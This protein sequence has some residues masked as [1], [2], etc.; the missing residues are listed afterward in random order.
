MPTQRVE[1]DA[2]GFH[3]VILPERGGSL[4]RVGWRHPDGE[5]RELFERA[6]EAAIEDLSGSLSKL[7][8]FVMIP[9][10]N[11]IDGARFMYDG[12]ERQLPLNRPEQSC[13]IHG[14]SRNAA[15]A[16]TQWEPQRI[17][18]EH[19]QMASD[20]PYCYRAEQEVTV[21]GGRAHFYL[22]V[23][24]RGSS[25]MPFG[26]GHHPWLPRT[27]HS[28]LQFYAEA[29]FLSDERT[30]PVEAAPVEGGPTDF[31][32]P[33]VLE[34][35]RGLDRHFA[36]WDGLAVVRQPDEG[37]IL[38]FVCDQGFRNVHIFVPEDRSS[39]CVEPVTHV[40]DVVNRRAFAPFGDMAR[41]EPGET[42]MTRMSLNPVV[43]G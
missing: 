3:I 35:M 29:T 31:T 21:V 42:L 4:A 20:T 23:E 39:F 16:V 11:R 32:L 5:W 1:I 30:F 24:N 17:M 12:G 7:S 27:P 22:T 25:A 8:S 43:T 19:E 15:W 36:R 38:E 26:L 40:T 41:L 10:V 28:Q 34:G 18:L 14:L 33:R 37:Y 2:E 6:E 9:F 13:A